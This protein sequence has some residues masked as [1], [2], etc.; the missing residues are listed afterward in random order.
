MHHADPPKAEV[1]RHTPALSE[2]QA[3]EL[4]VAKPTSTYLLSLVSSFLGSCRVKKKTTFRNLTAGEIYEIGDE[5]K[6]KLEQL[7]EEE[8]RA[9]GTCCTSV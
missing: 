5:S 1:D 4:I 2:S 8:K 6:Q 7:L 3:G 9:E